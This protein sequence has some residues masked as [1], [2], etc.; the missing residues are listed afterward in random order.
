MP[1][2]RDA[3]RLAAL[4]LILA[5]SAL[6]VTACQLIVED[7]AGVRGD[8]QRKATSTVVADLPEYDVSVSAV[9]FDPPIKQQTI[10][11]TQKAVKLLAAIENKG[12][13]PLTQLIVEA[14]MSSQKGDFSTQDKVQIDRLSPGETKVVEF[15][16]VAPVQMLPKSPSYRI[17]VTVDGQQP[18]THLRSNYREVIVR[19]VDSPQPDQ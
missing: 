4:L 16:G 14:R 18:G 10:P 8:T 15:A 7:P 3:A 17:L 1:N 9:D 2:T 11:S 6:I 13:M 19:V 12:T 5:A